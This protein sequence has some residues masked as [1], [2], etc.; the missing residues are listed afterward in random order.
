MKAIRPFECANCPHCQFDGGRIC[1][2]G[3]KPRRFRSGD[4]K[5]K[6]PDWCPRRKTPRELRV[7]G[8]RSER[9]RMMYALLWKEPRG[10]PD[11]DAFRYMVTLESHTDLTAA[12]FWERCQ[13]E[14]GKSLLSVTAPLY[15]VLEI[16]DG[17]CPAYFQRTETGYALIPSF[18]ATAARKNRARN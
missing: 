16:D 4:P 7:Y 11:L 8:F 14:S 18:D 13:S 5:R 1:A 3:K 15:G 12:E 17:L 9:D 10:L 6:P 2:G